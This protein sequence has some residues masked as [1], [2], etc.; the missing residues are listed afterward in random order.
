MSASRRQKPC[1]LD[2]P[3]QKQKPNCR[4]WANKSERPT[5]VCYIK[6][7]TAATTLEKSCRPLTG[8]PK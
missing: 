4:V 1:V 8:A 3:F 7:N 2:H 5:C 6:T